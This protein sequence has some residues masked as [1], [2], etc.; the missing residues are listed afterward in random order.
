MTSN[1]LRNEILWEETMRIDPDKQR[2]H[3]ECELEK[4]EE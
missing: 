4:T 1:K 3:Q 2:K